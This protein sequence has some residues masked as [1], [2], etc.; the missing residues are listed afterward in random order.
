[1]FQATLE[2][3]FQSLSQTCLTVSETTEMALRNALL[4]LQDK[5]K[6]ANTSSSDGDRLQLNEFINNYFS[7]A[8][9]SNA[10]KLR[11]LLV[12]YE[13]REFLELFSRDLL[14][15]FINNLSLCF[16]SENG[17][18]TENVSQ[19]ISLMELCLSFIEEKKTAGESLSPL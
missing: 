17:L 3:T 12:F 6:T 14:P 2:A 10:R 13:R 9:P 7:E 8:A 5:T 19:V 1:M 4:L 11:E 18:S 15:M 16:L